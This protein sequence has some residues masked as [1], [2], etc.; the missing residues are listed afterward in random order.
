MVEIIKDTNFHVIAT[1]IKL[2][3]KKR[4]M[5]SK[6]PVSDDVTYYVYC[7]DIGQIVLDPH[8]SIPASEAW[9]FKNPEALESV[10]TGLKEAAAKK[11]SKINLDEL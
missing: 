10:K 3:A 11:V 2:D 8:V 1:G 7:N 9:L 6:V 5:L 4:V